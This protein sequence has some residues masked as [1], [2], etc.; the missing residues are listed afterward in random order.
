MPA[1]SSKKNTG[2]MG[3]CD[4]ENINVLKVDKGIESMILFQEKDAVE[5]RKHS[6]VFT[7]ILL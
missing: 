7:I 2:D 5:T 3:S 6:T 4:N 1:L